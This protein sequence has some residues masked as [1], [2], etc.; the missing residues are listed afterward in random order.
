MAVSDVME[1]CP[2]A[3]DLSAQR[4][5]AL[6]RQLVTDGTVDRS[7]EGRIA[8]FAANGKPASFGFI[9]EYRENAALAERPLPPPPRRLRPY[10]QTRLFMHFNFHRE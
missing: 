10:W 2:E 4:V 5:S 7:V 3:G 1:T 6:L 8:F 9:T